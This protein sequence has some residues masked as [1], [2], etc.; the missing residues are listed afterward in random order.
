MGVQDQGRAAWRQL[1]AVVPGALL[2][3]RLQS[4]QAAQIIVAAAIS[5]LPPR[6]DDSHTNL[7]WR[8]DW[9]G[10]ATNV[11]PSRDG[12]RFALRVHDLALLSAVGDGVR[13]TLTLDG[14]SLSEAL[15]WLA[16][17]L[18]REGFDPDRLTTKKHYEIPAHAV[19]AGAPYRLD[20]DTFAELGRCYQ[21][22]WALASDV[23]AREPGASAP[24]CW[25]HHF[26]LATLITLAPATD[27]S[28]RTIGVGLSP[29]DDSYREPYFYVGPYP[30]PAVTSLHPLR[31]GRW[32]TDRWVGAVLP[33][34][35]LVPYADARAQAERARA[36]V[37][38]AVAAGRVALG[39]GAQDAGP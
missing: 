31:H 24:R 10:L 29:G 15:A 22:A 16:A 13:S 34:S 21:N 2:D 26:D 11:L 37:D 7:E 14:R 3:A 4:H 32:H 25:P 39:I 35:D 6:G 9:Q 12:L 36:F 19:A 5:Y 27:G 23:A 30:Y 1:G 38:E 18:G 33:A 20:P 28:S 17:E 8:P